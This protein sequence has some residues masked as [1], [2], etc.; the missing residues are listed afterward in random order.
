MILIISKI[1][2]IFSWRSST[3]KN[4][5]LKQNVTI[6]VHRLDVDPVGR[7]VARDAARVG[8]RRRRDARVR[9]PGLDVLPVEAVLGVPVALRLDVT[10]RIRVFVRVVGRLLLRQPL[11]LP[12]LRPPVLK[13][14]LPKKILVKFGPD[15]NTSLAYARKVK[16]KSVNRKSL[17]RNISILCSRPGDLLKGLLKPLR[18]IKL[19]NSAMR[20]E[21]R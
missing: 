6:S 2:K 18:S 1:V 15:Y 9:R 21:Y 13:P 12:E 8:V 17:I 7:L 20:A 5:Y 3:K 4:L 19:V 16:S 10:R 11:L 14:Y